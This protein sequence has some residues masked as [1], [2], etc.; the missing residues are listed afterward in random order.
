MPLFFAPFSL[1]PPGVEAVLLALVLAAAVYDVRYRRIPNWL[2]LAGVLIG[3]ALNAFLDQ[4]RRGMFVASMLGLAIAFIVYFGLYALHAMG[5]G[6]V[7]LMAAVG[8]IVGWPNWFGIF[9]VTA[10]IGGIN[11][12]HWV[13]DL[14][15]QGQDAFPLL[16][17]ALDEMQ[18]DSGRADKFRK[19]FGGLVKRP[20]EPSADQPLCTRLFHMLNAYPGPGDGHVAEFFPQLMTPLI[21]N[22]EHYQGEAIKYVYESYPKL[23]EKMIAT[24]THDAPID[25]EDFAKELAWEHTQFLDILASQQGNL[26]QVFHVNVPNKGYIHNLPDEAVVEVPATVDKA[27]IHPLALGDLPLPIVPVMA[28]K[29]ASI[30]LIIE[31]AIEGSREKA[32]QAILNDP[33]CTDIDKGA[34]L[35]NELIEAQLE[36]LP[37]FRGA[38]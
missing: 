29:L 2:S 10:I 34:L 22:V 31:A 35:V 4:G 6:D 37:R 3:V 21:G 13:M 23:R 30:D 8:A 1:P 12:C 11:H 17:A 38:A 15:I 16:H 14:R 36:Y 24:G 7:K 32:I 5:A 28:H 25:T 20:H 18:G 33:H 26:G 19:E 27:G 9:I